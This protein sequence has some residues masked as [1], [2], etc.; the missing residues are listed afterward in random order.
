MTAAE[1]T[2]STPDPTARFWDRIAERYARKP[3]ADEAA[4]Q[5]KL[6]ITRDYLRP[7]MAVLEF[8]CGTG[9]TAL[10]HAPYVRQILATDISAKM[11]EI[12]EAKARAAGAGNVAFRRVGI[13]ELSV[14][15][16]SYDVV[17][18]LSILHLLADR[19]AAIS[20]VYRMLKPGGVFVSS[21]ACL[22]D[23]LPIF[24]YIGP[25]G[26]VLGLLPLL[27]VFTV[28][29][30]EASLTGAGFEI[31]RQWQPGRRKGVFIVAR[32]PG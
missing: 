5:E 8:G 24:R 6:R 29:E 12:A 32:R 2:T 31:E 27:S 26:R 15:D 3:V 19:D 10:A 9:S 28:K 23:F 25:L 18:G 7:D 22:G 13:G 11:I 17:L 4:Y 20:K 21:T 16:G 1:Q 14:P 30:L